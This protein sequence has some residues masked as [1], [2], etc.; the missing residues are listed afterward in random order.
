[1]RSAPTGLRRL[2]QE[3]PLGLGMGVGIF[4]CWWR[5]R[6]FV[7]M[8]WPAGFDWERY[9]RE[10]WAYTHPGTMVSTW[11]EPLYLWLLSTV[12][13]DIGWAA[14]GLLLSS[15]ALVGAV[16]GAGLLGRALAGPWVG[17]CAAVAIPLTPQLVESSRWVNLYPLLGAATV[18]GLAGCVGFARWSGWGWALLGGV[19]LGLAWG[20]D[21]R[22]VPLIPGMLGLFVLGL[23]GVRGTPRRAGLVLL[24]SMGVGLGPLSQHGLRVMPRETTAEVAVIL[25][26]GELHKISQ[27]EN[28]VMREA[29]QDQQA[30]LIH[31]AG[32]LTP[33]ASALQ[34][35]NLPRIDR[36]LP[37][38][39]GL[40][41][42]FF[43]LALLPG[44]GGRRQSLIAAL[45][46]VPP[47][48][49]TWAMSRWI[50]I[51]P[52][53]M[54]PVAM[55]AAVVGPVAVV[56]LIRTLSRRPRWSAIG[57]A[58]ALALTLWQWQEGPDN[59]GAAEPLEHSSTYRMAAPMLETVL[60]ERAEGEGVLDCS[61]S[62]IAVAVYPRSLVPAPQDHEGHDWLRCARWISEGP[63]GSTGMLLTG[64]RTQVPGLDPE[65]LPP[66]WTLLKRTEGMGQFMILWRWAL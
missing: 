32:L 2:L 25:R 47:L 36:I 55:T 30:V 21:S 26:G 35:D 61:E 17:A 56:Q 57:A 10:T 3:L 62:H 4:L 16:V 20:V 1:M 42:V 23:Q 46:L 64:T 27:S 34:G 59:R 7:P 40:T 63:P 24:F 44:L 5:G 8:V 51:N 41:L 37:L 43:P 50:F 22:T 14:A 53:Y 19:G 52:R 12:G 60:A 13:A 33:C 29:C 31:V 18:L 49:M 48:A 58:M 9:L 6:A 39:T 11:L 65:R 66:P 15:A 38:G 28:R 54:M 45:A